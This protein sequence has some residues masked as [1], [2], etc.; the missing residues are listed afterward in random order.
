MKATV[1]QFAPL[2]IGDLDKYPDD[3]VVID[4]GPL[5]GSVRSPVGWRYS[6]STDEALRL[7]ADL[8]RVLRTIHHDPKP[9][10]NP[11]TGD[12]YAY[13]DAWPTA[14]NIKFQPRKRGEQ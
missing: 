12:R 7:Y 10:V 5:Y 2:A 13:E 1:K 8:G 3:G 9:Y 4:L 6:I 11:E 14:I